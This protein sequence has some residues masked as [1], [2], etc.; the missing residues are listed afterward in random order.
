MP[1]RQC[2]LEEQ[3]PDYFVPGAG[4]RMPSTFPYHSCAAAR[5]RK[6]APCGLES[7][8]LHAP[9]RYTLQASSGRCSPYRR[10]GPHSCSSPL[11]ELGDARDR[12]QTSN[13]S[14]HL[15]HIQIQNQH[16]LDASGLQQS[17]CRCGLLPH[18]SACAKAYSAHD[19]DYSITKCVTISLMIQKPDPASECAW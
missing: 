17:S 9:S 10:P 12:N 14:R 11:L 2:R 19:H 4:R 5:A 18:L 1:R 8:K 7:S 6:R 3:C 16:T 15:M 13:R